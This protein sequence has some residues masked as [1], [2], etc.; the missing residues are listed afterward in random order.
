LSRWVHIHLRV[1]REVAVD[2]P[3][4]HEVGVAKRHVAH[5][6]DLADGSALLEAVN[7]HSLRST[8]PV[9]ERQRVL[10][11]SMRIMQAIGIENDRPADQVVRSIV[12][13]ATTTPLPIVVTVHHVDG[14]HLCT[15]VQ[16]AEEAEV[17]K[18]VVRADIHRLPPIRVVLPIAI[19]SRVAAWLRRRRYR[20]ASRL[21]LA[22]DS[23]RV[24]VS[25]LSRRGAHAWLG[26]ER[27]LG[28]RL[29]RGVP[30]S[31]RR[32]RGDLTFFQRLVF[33]VAAELDYRVRGTRGAA[34]TGA[35]FPAL[36]PAVGV[37]SSFRGVRARR[38]L[39]VDR[40]GHAA[41]ARGVDFVVLL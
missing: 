11:R 28:R 7:V 3:T 31:A 29:W 34:L 25:G 38:F 17:V 4:R 12:D 9:P 10:A 8:D 35:T 18:L 14:G 15:G 24:G 20:R 2:L 22:L 33:A 16:R 21:G 1:Q 6:L 19:I 23:R 41:A 5:L 30:R 36:A 37:L 26:L 13:L 39:E 27:T 40:L 32:R